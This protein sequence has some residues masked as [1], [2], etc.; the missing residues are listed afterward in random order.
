MVHIITHFAFSK[1]NKIRI[2]IN[3]VMQYT[4]EQSAIRIENIKMSHFTHDLVLLR[5]NS[6]RKQ[7]TD[8]LTH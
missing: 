2:K 4:W 8:S 3:K 6:F 1:I 7:S 5:K